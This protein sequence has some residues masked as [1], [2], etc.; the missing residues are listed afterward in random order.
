[1]SALAD[2]KS[3]AA[4]ELRAIEVSEKE[5]AAPP[6]LVLLLLFSR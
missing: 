6:P 5:A 3:T 4:G 1:M 2:M